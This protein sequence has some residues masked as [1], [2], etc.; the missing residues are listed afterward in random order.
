MFSKYYSALYTITTITLYSV[1]HKHP[2]FHEGTKLPQFIHHFPFQNVKTV[3]KT[4]LCWGLSAEPL[5]ISKVMVIEREGLMIGNR[6]QKQQDGDRRCSA[7]TLLKLFACIRTSYQPHTSRST[8]ALDTP[9][10]NQRLDWPHQGKNTEVDHHSSF[11]RML[12]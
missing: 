8:K 5:S 3:R 7:R 6:T 11:Y 9:S 4:S 2:D 1:K 12:V 10:T